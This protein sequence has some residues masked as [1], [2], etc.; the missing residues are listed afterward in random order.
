MI[1]ETTHSENNLSGRES[2]VSFLAASALFFGVVEIATLSLSLL[3]VPISR[4]VA[5]GIFL[6]SAVISC[7]Y[8]RILP[9]FPEKLPSPQ[10][11]QEP[12]RG[13]V[14]VVLGTVVLIYLLLWLLAY[15][16]PD[17]SYDGLYYHNPP[18]HF[19]ALKGYVY[20]ITTGSPEHWGPIITFAWNGYPKGIELLNFVFLQ[21]TQASRLLNAGNLILLPWGALA[22]VA[23][24]RLLGA[25][26]RFSW[27]SALVFCLIPI[28]IA[29]SVTTMVDL[30][31][32][33]CYLAVF[34][35]LIFTSRRI[36][37]GRIPFR[38]LPGLGAALGLAVAAK[39]PGIILLT[40]AVLLISL[41]F[42]FPRETGPGRRFP[43]ILIFILLLVLIA[44]LTGGFWHARNWW[45][46]G[47]PFY[48]VGLNVSGHTIFPGLR[49]GS[50]FGLPP[51]EPGTEKWSQL[52]RI[53]FNWLG[54]LSHWQRSVYAYDSRSGGLG[55]FWIIG[56]VPALLFLLPDFRARLKNQSLNI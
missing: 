26:P 6:C 49:F 17:F 16:L 50:I 46:M 31:A 3:A 10:P 19:W 14:G 28:N 11:G 54:I 35:L 42:L 7:C 4:V 27:L 30:P 51:Y 39:G 15:T 55:L 21:A 34:A 2:L 47:S 12:S 56:A 37:R 13:L 20:W 5:G 44:A 8:Y 45:R 52:G 25:P 23:L 33:A 40:A 1:K 36:D 9:S 43:R 24:C 53:I 48:P 41:H 22:A 38:I 29:Q 32:A 18:I